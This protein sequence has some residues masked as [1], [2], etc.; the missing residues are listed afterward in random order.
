MVSDG[1]KSVVVVEVRIWDNFL[2]GSLSGVGL[3]H[4]N[5]VTLGA[6]RPSSEHY[7]MFLG[8]IH[9]ISV[10]KFIFGNLL[11]DCM[12]G[13]CSESWL[14]QLPAHGHESRAVSAVAF[15]SLGLAVG[16]MFVNPCLTSRDH[17]RSG[18]ALKVTF[19]V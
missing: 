15:I 16:N 12:H 14:L 18:G 3:L 1:H 4:S 19:F 17:S 8:V 11:G 10:E 5:I 13:E 9:G 7:N 6:I 2:D